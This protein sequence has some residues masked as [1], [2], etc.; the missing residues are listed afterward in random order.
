MVSAN[1]DLVGKFYWCEY[2]RLWDEIVDCWLVHEGRTSWF[3]VRQ[4]GT[5]TVR[6]H[7]TPVPTDCVFDAPIVIDGVHRAPER[8]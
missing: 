8:K 7:C 2:W 6:D 4:A 5:Q 3:R 1:P